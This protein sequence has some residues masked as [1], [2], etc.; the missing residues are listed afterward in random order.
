M[1]RI[2]VL[3]MAIA[4]GGTALANE[5]TKFEAVSKIS[6]VIVYSD[7]AMVKRAFSAKLP[8][9]FVSIAI[10]DLPAKLLNESVRVT[11]KGTTDVT[12]FS[13]RVEE[14]FLEESAQEAVRALQDQ[15]EKLEGQIKSLQDRKTV[16]ASKKSFVEA[17]SKS[18]S[19]SISKDIAVQRPSIDEWAGML[20]F[21]DKSLNEI[22]SESRDIENEIKDLNN[23][24]S[25]IEREMSARQ[26]LSGESR[27]AVVVDLDIADPGTIS[28]ELSY[29]VTGASWTPIYDIRASSENDT[30]SIVF[31]ANVKQNTGEDW[32]DVQIELSTAKPYAGHGPRKPIPWYLRIKTPVLSYRGGRVS[33]GEVA[34]QT[35]GDDTR[36]KQDFMP[37]NRPAP[38]IQMQETQLSVA[39]VSQQLISTSFILKQT[40]SIPSDNKI[41]KVSVKVASTEGKK[42]Y[43]AIPK[44]SDNVYLRS[45]IINKTSFPLL[46]GDASIFFDGG[47]VS[48]TAIPLVV[49]SEGF[50]LFLGI[51]DNIR[52]KRE[53]A[54][55]FVDETGVMSR[56]NRI[57]F[58]YNITIEN[59]RKNESKITILDQI[60][61]SRDDRIDVK[62]KDISPDPQYKA[63]D[64]QKGI[65]RWILDMKAGEKN[66]LSFNYE[67]KFPSDVIVDGLN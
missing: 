39:D 36:N 10:P 60:P 53:L 22:A 43:Y 48:T 38:M 66:Q 2:L 61:V 62:L 65:L 17:I 28:M 35:D 50:D 56:K 52:L 54:K 12:I 3:L 8:T 19:E 11:G 37:F 41:K 27:K 20:S 7:R 42:E 15:K 26:Y 33:P 40:E 4:W 57:E 31:M 18:T 63:D 13:V 29:I 9:G 14:E 32:H 5:A 6:S 55:R 58:T 34:F 44:T 67:V 24:K 47:F 25:I 21:V 59:L 16:L 1:R 23:K 30:I 49:P 64:E 46:P 45:K 51:D